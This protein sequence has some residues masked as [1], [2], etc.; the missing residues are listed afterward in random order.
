MTANLEG[1]RLKLDRA[2]KHLE[3][4]EEA[5]SDFTK[6]EL[7]K[8][9]I[10]HEGGTRLWVIEEPGEVPPEFGPLISDVL[11][12]LRSALDYLAT[13]LVKANNPKAGL[14]DVGFP[15]FD[16]IT[17]FVERGLPM[18][19]KMSKGVQAAIEAAQPYHRPTTDW[20]MDR[21]L[22]LNRLNNSYKH[23][24]FKLVAL[25]IEGGHGYTTIEALVPNAGP[26]EG[27]TIML[28]W[29]DEDPEVEVNWTF[30][31]DVVFAESPWRDR[32]V[33]RT[34]RE[35]EEVTRQTILEVAK[36]GGLT[37]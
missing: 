31:L 18:I 6:S 27:R 26:L 17:E 35:L 9:T 36:A 22:L 15:I 16:N 11:H 21:L 10:E 13:Q 25:S 33:C 30:V 37:A 19:L 2:G 24:D 32:R 12:N 23:S 28:A 34:L 3:D 20:S 29:P 4:L 8:V 14:S 7:E 5:V 1:T